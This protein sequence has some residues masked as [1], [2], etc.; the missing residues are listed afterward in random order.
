MV[1]QAGL[2]MLWVARGECTAFTEDEKPK[3]RK[4]GK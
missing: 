3:K 1:T 4:A 2:M